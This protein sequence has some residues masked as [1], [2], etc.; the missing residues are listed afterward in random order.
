LWASI[1]CQALRNGLVLSL[2]YDGYFRGVEV[3]AVGVTKN[4]NEIMRAWQVSGGSVSN[5]PI[6]WKLLRLDE[7]IGGSITQDKSAAP[8]QGYRRDDRA[9]QRIICQL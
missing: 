1:A 3:H 4:G 9:M 7:A 6:G 5:E 2:H 8:R